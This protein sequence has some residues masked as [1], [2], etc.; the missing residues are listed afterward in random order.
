MRRLPALILSLGLTAG[1]ALGA[2]SP[3]P[4]SLDAILSSA[5]ASA[6]RDIPQDRLIYLRLPKGLVVIE[7]AP[8]FAPDHV[9]NLR[10]LAG[11]RFFDGLTVARVQD[12]YVVQWGD[13]EARRPRGGALERLPPEFDHRFTAD[14]PFTALP[15]LD[16]YAPQTGF[17]D[18]FPAARDPLSGQAWLTH[19]YGM[20]G[21]GRDNAA[22]SGDA[23]ELYAVIGQA[24]RQLDRNV[25]LMGRVIE[26][27][28]ILS[29]L[30]RGHGPLGFYEKASEH[31]A[32]LSLAFGDQL[33][34]DRQVHFQALRTDSS[35]F[36]ALVQNRRY[37]QDA[38]Y[39]A[40]AG[41]I[42]VCNVPLPVRV[43]P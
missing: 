4:Q 33:P 24:P 28:D 2:T 26:G 7:V 8:R 21:V 32:I 31:T 41:R 38:W 37:R 40:P 39:K 11:A 3:P 19:C 27:I 9:A 43:A 12:D 5:P 20:V 42:D 36:Q 29:S 17:T 18:G 6:W 25:A 16:T 34:A 10:L 13:A 1:S 22:D 30:P 15:D 14:E 23:S 35:T